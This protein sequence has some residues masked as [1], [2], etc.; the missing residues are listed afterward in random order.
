MM[1]LATDPA[2]APAHAYKLAAIA[3][4]LAFPVAPAVQIFGPRVWL[5]LLL[6]LL[7]TLGHLALRIRSDGV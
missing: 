1:E 5:A 3:N 6:A 2:F 7:A 4:T